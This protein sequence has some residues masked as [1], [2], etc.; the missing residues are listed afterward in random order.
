MVR[1]EKSFVDLLVR[2]LLNM[3]SQFKLQELGS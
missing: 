1:V 2:E 3:G